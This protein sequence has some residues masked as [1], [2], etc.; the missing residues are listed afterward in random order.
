MKSQTNRFIQMAQ[1][2]HEMAPYAVPQYDWLQETAIITLRSLQANQSLLIDLGGGS[3]RLVKRYLEHFPTAK[4]VMVDSS[5]AFLEIA[6][7]YLREES[8]RIQLIQSRLEGPWEEHIPEAPTAIVSMSCIHHFPSSEKQELYQRATQLLAPGGIFMNI[9]EMKAPD[10]ETYQEDMMDWWNH[11]TAVRAQ[12][13]KQQSEAYQQFYHHFK[14]WKIRNIDHYGQPKQKGDDLHDTTAAQLSMLKASG[15][16]K[17]QS[18]FHYRLW[19]AI[20][21]IK[22]A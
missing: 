9:D 7:I 10:S 19:T 6:K 13:P 4:A 5:P 1:C 12:V 17:V 11:V 22:P 15:L 8:D 21:G 18:P 14:N 16:T 20:A 2:F 3:G